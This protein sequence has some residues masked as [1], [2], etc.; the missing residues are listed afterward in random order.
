MRNPNF[1]RGLWVAL[2][3]GGVITAYLAVALQ[4]RWGDVVRRTLW[5]A[6]YGSVLLAMTAS[7]VLGFGVSSERM[8]RYVREN[9]PVEFTN[10]WV[11]VLAILAFLGGAWYARREPRRWFL[12]GLAGL[13]F[14]VA[15]EEVAWGQHLFYFDAPD[16]IARY[17]YQDE[18]TLHNLVVGGIP[19]HYAQSIGPVGIVILFLT[20]QWKFPNQARKYTGLKFS[21]PVAALL[22]LT[23]AFMF[24]SSFPFP[25]RVEDA[26]P[27][28]RIP[29]AIFGMHS[30]AQSELAEGVFA[31]LMLLASIAL[32]IQVRRP[33]RDKDTLPTR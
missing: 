17:N 9:G 26:V 5:P 21:W 12:L 1:W 23:G 2:T 33:S 8:L 30:T 18:T 22:L 16:A 19:L 15:G 6:V 25:D 24:L 31:V 27:A 13:C 14:F 32:V 10:F 11:L 20:W 7:F 4:S 29:V 3:L 28:A